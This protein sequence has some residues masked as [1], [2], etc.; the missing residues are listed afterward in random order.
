MK[1]ILKSIFVVLII[2]LSLQS[3]ETTYYATTQD[4]IHVEAQADVVRSNVDFSIVIRNGIPHYYGSS[5]LYYLY[6]G[7]YYYPYWY[8]NN[9]Y[10]RVYSRPFNHLKFRPYFRP[11]RHDYKFAPGVHKGFGVPHNNMRS[12]IKPYGHRHINPPF[13]RSVRPN[14]NRP[15]ITRPNNTVRPGIPQTPSRPQ[16]RRESVAPRTMP[17]RGGHFGGRRN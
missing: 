15:N 1:T 11:T 7:L 3:C 9:W 8:N 14:S 13:N 16:M 17:Q 12:N 2:M 10:V 5:I 6:N 4:D